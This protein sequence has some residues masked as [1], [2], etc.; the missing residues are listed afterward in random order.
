MV[1]V[2]AV[3]VAVAAGAAVAVLG[4]LVADDLHAAG[5]TCMSAAFTGPGDTNGGEWWW[6]GCWGRWER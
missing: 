4:V 6:F 1:A 2:V 3:A 5:F